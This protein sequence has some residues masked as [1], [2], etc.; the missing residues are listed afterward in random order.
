MVGFMQIVAHKSNSTWQ[1]KHLYIFL[2]LLVQL[3]NPSLGIYL[4]GL[5]VWNTGSTTLMPSFYSCSFAVALSAAVSRLTII[6]QHF[7]V[8]SYD[9]YALSTSAD[10]QD[11]T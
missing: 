4:C 8:N 11:F 3:F 10:T 7:S 6:K 9:K 1:E 5:Q 2:K